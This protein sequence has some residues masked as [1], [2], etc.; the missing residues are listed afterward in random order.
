MQEKTKHKHALHKD[1]S[2]G[3]IVSYGMPS[4]EE[5]TT[6]INLTPNSIYLWSY[7][8]TAHFVKAASIK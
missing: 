5:D 7:S 3:I 1:T 2:W 8:E 4:C 6:E